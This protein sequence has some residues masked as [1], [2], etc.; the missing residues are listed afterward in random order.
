VQLQDFME[1]TSATPKQV[2]E[3]LQINTESRLYALKL[4]FLF[5]A[6]IALLMVLPVRR[7]PGFRR[8]SAQ[9]KQDNAGHP[10]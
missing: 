10:S 4:A 7:L 6:G 9:N 1:A 2:N 5:L 8:I 3:A